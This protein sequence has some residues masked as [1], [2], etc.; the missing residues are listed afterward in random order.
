MNQPPKGPT[1]SNV[2]QT[3]IPAAYVAEVLEIVR[4]VRRLCLLPPTTLDKLQKDADDW[5]EV[6]HGV[7]PLA[8]LR[9]VYLDAY[10][11]HKVGSIF[12]AAE[13][14][15]AWYRR[16]AGM[17]MKTTFAE[18]CPLCRSHNE[19][20]NIRPCPFHQVADRPICHRCQV[21]HDALMLEV[22][23]ELFILCTVC[24][25]F[26]IPREDALR[27]INRE[28]EY[29][30]G[31]GT[32]PMRCIATTPV[33]DMTFRCQ[34]TQGHQGAHDFDMKA[35][36][37]LIPQSSGLVRVVQ[38]NRCTYVNDSKTPELRLQCILPK[39]HEGRCRFSSFPVSEVA[40]EDAGP[41]GTYVEDKL[42]EM[43]E[44]RICPRC[45]VPLGVNLVEYYRSKNAKPGFVAFLMK[46]PTCQRNTLTEEKAD[47]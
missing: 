2:K 8:H 12:E 47:A 18:K 24:Q 15:Q 46:C 31:P 36:E 17:T 1:D 5:A 42:K 45:E 26:T 29:H 16:T 34:L 20:E 33:A 38:E 43:I 9:S 27:I 3:N 14:L 30:R 44:T 11:E 32:V 10:R 4:S 41:P 40:I 39:D 7:I 19:G 13:L 22:N 25:R 23:R 35:D 6:F 28:E 37:S 21:P